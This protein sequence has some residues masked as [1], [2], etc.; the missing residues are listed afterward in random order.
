MLAYNLIGSRLVSLGALSIAIRRAHANRGL[1][2][3]GRTIGAQ[4][5]ASERAPGRER[6]GSRSHDSFELRRGLCELG[7]RPRRLAQENLDLRLLGSP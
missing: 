4:A 1:S 5:A 3:L 7:N 2:A 6:V